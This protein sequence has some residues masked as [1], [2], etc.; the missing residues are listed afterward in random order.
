MDCD[1]DS[2]PLEDDIKSTLNYF[3]CFCLTLGTKIRTIFCALLLKLYIFAILGPLNKL[4]RQASMVGT[5]LVSSSKR[6][7]A[8]DWIIDSRCT[9]HMAS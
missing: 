9:K 8:Y 7:P 4:I 6:K 5:I 3:L 1:S 2:E